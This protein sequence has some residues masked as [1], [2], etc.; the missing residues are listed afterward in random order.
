MTGFLHAIVNC[1]GDFAPAGRAPQRIEDGERFGCSWWADLGQ[2]GLREARRLICREGWSRVKVDGR[3]LDLC[4]EC[5]AHHLSTRPGEVS[6][7]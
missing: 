1:D 4:P 5:H 2:V 3:M 7:D 6:N